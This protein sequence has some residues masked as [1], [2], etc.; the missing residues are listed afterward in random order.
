MR[1]QS[2]YGPEISLCERDGTSRSEFIDSGAG[3]SCVFERSFRHE[4]LAILMAAV[5]LP[6]QIACGGGSTGQMNGSGG[7]G[8]TVHQYATGQGP[9]WVAAG[10]FNGDKNLDLAVTNGADNTVSVLLGNGDGTFQK[11]VDYPADT[12]LSA[13][14]VGDF[15][16]DGKQDLVVASTSDGVLLGNGDGTFQTM[17]PLSTR[18]IDSTA[19]AIGDLNGDGKLDLVFVA[20]GNG[21]QILIGNG[22][23]TFIT[24]PDQGWDIFAP[25]WVVMGDFNADSRLD[26]VMSSDNHGS[27]WAIPVPGNG[28]GTLS[29]PTEFYEI[30][31]AEA[32]SGVVLSDF[33]G[34]G[35]SDIATG[36][37]SYS[38]VALLLGNGDGTFQSPTEF[39]IG[40]TTMMAL[41]VADFNNDGKPDLVVVNGKNLDGSN[42]ANTVSILLGNGDGTFQTHVDY[43]T[44]TSPTSVVVGDFNGD[45][46]VDL[47]V[48]NQDD[49]TVSI[50]LGNGDGTFKNKW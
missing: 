17:V 11:N 37:G 7:P 2:S 12:L 44:G 32:G 39:T 5:L 23:G 48:T 38:G 31:G 33:N 43:P 4:V 24:E 22:D 16:G 18:V 25:F 19:V 28:D 6:L 35:T 29:F 49:N 30:G 46:I 36:S 40:S 13:V 50:L 1:E 27:G 42:G 20:G 45:G 10:D 15:N 34:D 3:I 8:G 21:G 47:A 41:A 9:T 14:A 26:V